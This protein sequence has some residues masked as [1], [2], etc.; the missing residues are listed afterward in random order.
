M[1][2][3]PEAKMLYS[4][5]ASYQRQNAKHLPPLMFHPP[6][7]QKNARKRNTVKRQAS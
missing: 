3:C 2:E 1:K 7:K 6:T 5:K 4:E